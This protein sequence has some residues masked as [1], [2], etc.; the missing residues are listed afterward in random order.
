MATRLLVID[1]EDGGDF[2]LS[3]EAGTLTIGCNAQNAEAVLHDLR[4]ARIHCEVEF[5]GSSVVVGS[6]ALAGDKANGG[7]S[8]HQELH[9]G[10]AVRVGRSRLRLE[11][12]P[13][14][15]VTQ[16]A[17]VTVAKRTPAPARLVKRLV[18]I[19]GADRGRFFPLPESGIVTI[20]KNPRCADIILHDLYVSRVHCELRID[21]DAVIVAHVEGPHETLINGQKIAE[22]EIRLGEILRI[23]NSHLRLEIDLVEE[24]SN[25]SARDAPSTSGAEEEG[26]NEV[27]E[28]EGEEAELI[29]EEEESDSEESAGAEESSESYSLP[30]PPVDELLKLE[31]QP[32]GHF[33]I[34]PLLGRGQSG[35][36]FRAVDARTSQTVALKVLSPDFPHSEMELQRF[37]R[38]L[39][40]MPL[41]QHTHLVTLHGAGKTGR[42]CWISREYVEG[43]SLA[44]LVQRLKAAGKYDWMRACRLAID[45]GKALDFLHRN[46]V[47]H[48]NIT[49]RN[50]LIR[51]SDKVVK[52]ADLM[53]SRALEGTRLQKAILG[54]KLLAEQLYLAPEQTDPH[55]PVAPAADLYALGIVS[56]VLLTGQPP[57]TGDSPRDLRAQIREGKFVKPSKLQSGIPAPFEAAVL[58]LLAHRPEDRFQTAAE[59]LA[60]VEPL[61]EWKKSI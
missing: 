39:K 9:P 12:E 47:T 15:Q 41:L 14:P 17:A 26:T 53:L 20:G 30:H 28:E 18:V 52:L 40:A 59:M 44:R 10:E 57:F 45:L 49:P 21:G 36:V 27:E 38:A 7:A 35:I 29:E 46:R 42:C 51:G 56:Y 60:V 3:V 6:P 13:D 34:G 25:G 11:G 50:I 48:G 54:K 61:F 5:E 32:F 43:E 8:R 33:Q 58:K 22:Q 37:I 23:G 2:F 31:G 55:A 1:G 16:V 24:G 4:I 19:D